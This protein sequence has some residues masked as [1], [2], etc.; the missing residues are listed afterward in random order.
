MKVYHKRRTMFTKCSISI[1]MKFMFN[2]K[3]LPNVS[4]NNILL[5]AMTK[6]KVYE[7]GLRCQ[8]ISCQNPYSKTNS[9]FF[10]WYSIDCITAIANFLSKISFSGSESLQR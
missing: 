2:K 3:N 5:Q 10:G 6:S 4:F 8:A 7:L 9:K 1:Q